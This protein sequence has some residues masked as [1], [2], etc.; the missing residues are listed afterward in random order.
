MDLIC[1]GF[2]SVYDIECLNVVEK[3]KTIV[4]DYIKARQRL[5]VHVLPFITNRILFI[6]YNH[7]HSRE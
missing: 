4:L 5:H 3:I 6:C 2:F 1:R 7:F